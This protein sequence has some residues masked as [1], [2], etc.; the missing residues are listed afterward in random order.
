MAT[1]EQDQANW[2]GYEIVHNEWHDYTPHQR[3]LIDAVWQGYNN[4]PVGLEVISEN[5]WW[6]NFMTY[7]PDI[8]FNLQI[9][10]GRGQG[11]PPMR[12]FLDSTGG[13]LAVSWEYN[14]KGDASPIYYRVGCHHD[15]KE[16]E[17]TYGGQHT[18]MCSVCK[19]IQEVDSSG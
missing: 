6:Y 12:V 17:S 14:H 10:R 2:S 7:M 3:D 5:N 13:G 16:I 18:Y 11:M 9:W 1:T 4:E 15:W 8:I 19:R